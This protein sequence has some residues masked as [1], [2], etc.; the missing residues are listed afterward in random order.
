MKIEVEKNNIKLILKT[1]SNISKEKAN[2]VVGIF[3][4]IIDSFSASTDNNVKPILDYTKKQ[5]QI[6]EKPKMI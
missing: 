2:E 1:E 6:I 3:C 4:N 5:E